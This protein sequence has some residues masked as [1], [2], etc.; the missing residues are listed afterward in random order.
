MTDSAKTSTLDPQAHGKAESLRR[1]LIRGALGTAG[2]GVLQRGL[3]LLTAIVLARAL[4]ADGYGYYAFAIAAVGFIA[5]PTQLGLPTLLMREVAAS[6][7]RGDWSLMR[8]MRRRATQ[9]AVIAVT[10]SMTIIGGGLLVLP[11]EIPALDPATLALAIVLLPLGVAMAVANS[12]LSGLRL[13]IHATWPGSALQPLIFLLVLLALMAWAQPLQP[14][15]AVSANIAATAAA[16]LAAA[17]LIRRHWPKETS[18]AKPAYRTRSWLK[19][20]FPF[21]MIAGI[22][23]INQKTDILMLGVMTTAEDVGL[24]NIAIQ[25]SMLV[26]F[27]LF[28]FNGVLA[29]NVARLQCTRSATPV[30][31][32]ADPDNRRHVGLRWR[33]GSCP[34][35]CR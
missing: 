11:G 20:L 29:P 3:S 22:N 12:I 23:I 28:A 31:A 24:Y 21:T 19:S 18:N 10:L 2:L 26:T 25:G 17:Y 6:H 32:I 15:M 1:H 4:G 13:I 7:A 14:P 33:H 30:A 5:I 35:C 27:A 34:L 9:L 16:F 8:G